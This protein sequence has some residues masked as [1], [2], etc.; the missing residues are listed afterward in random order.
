MKNALVV[1]LIALVAGIALFAAT[2][3]PPASEAMPP[4]ATGYPLIKEAYVFASANPEKLDGVPCYCGCMQHP[5]GGRLHSRGL[6]DCY[7][8]GDAF[9]R[10]AS[11]CEMC[12][13][14]A[15]SVKK[16]DSEGKSK[17]EIVR[18]INAKYAGQM[19]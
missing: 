13:M 7:K 15:L 1:S 19:H 9:E 6:L 2:A 17:E 8:N 18:A 16:M 4:Y 14:D 5:H 12:I 10:H 11:E 3:R